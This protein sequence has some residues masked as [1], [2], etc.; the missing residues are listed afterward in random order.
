[1]NSVELF[2]TLP[3]NS[4]SLIKARKPTIFAVKCL[5]SGIGNNEL[6]YPNTG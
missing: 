6:T 2:F 5:I 4:L 3:I 1:M